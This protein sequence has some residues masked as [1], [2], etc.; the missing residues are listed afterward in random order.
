MTALHFSCTLPAGA[1]P[2]QALVVASLVFC[3]V[4]SLGQVVL[5]EAANP[6]AQSALGAEL[7]PQG[8]VVA[9]FVSNEE[10]RWSR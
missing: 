8:P 9:V 10:F 7:R 5:I 6:E 2:S 3:F 1:V 4:T